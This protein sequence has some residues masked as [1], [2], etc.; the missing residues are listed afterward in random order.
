MKDRLFRASLL[1]LLSASL[2]AAGAPPEK[3]PPPRLLDLHGDP[4]PQGAVARL[5]S[6]RL[7][8]AGLADWAFLP[9]G[10][11]VA[12]V[13]GDGFVRFWDLATGRLVRTS[14]APASYA[15]ALSSDGR[16]V[17]GNSRS[18]VWVRDTSS[19]E[20]LN[21]ILYLRETPAEL[22]FAPDGRSLLAWGGGGLDL[23]DWPNGRSRELPGSRAY[24]SPEGGRVVA[25]AVEDGTVQGLTVI[26]RATRREVYRVRGVFDASA[27]SPDGKRLAVLG[28]LSGAKRGEDGEYGVRVVDFATGKELNRFQLKP[29]FGRGSLAFSPD[30][31]TL[32]VGGRFGGCLLDPD[33]GK[34]TRRVADCAERLRYSPDGK[35]LA[36]AAGPRL[37]LWDTATRRELHDQFGDFV[38]PNDFPYRPPPAASWDG[39]R[40]ASVDAVT[41]DLAVWDLADG[42]VVR[43]V[44]HKDL[45]RW[46]FMT[47]LQ[48][49]VKMDA[50]VSNVQDLAVADSGE[51]MVAYLFDKG[52]L[53][54]DVATGFERNR[55]PMPSGGRLA[56]GGRWV[57]QPSLEGRDAVTGKTLFKHGDQLPADPWLNTDPTILFAWSA[58]G[59]TAVLYH[60]QIKGVGLTLLAVESGRILARLSEPDVITARHL[61]GALSPDGRLLA[62]WR[63]TGDY[64]PLKLTVW[65]AATGKEVAVVPATLMGTEQMAFGVGGRLLVINDSAKGVRMWQL[66]TGRERPWFPNPDPVSKEWYS[67]AQGMLV[68]PDG[69]RLVA[70]HPDGTGIVWDL[71]ANA[72]PPA[73]WIREELDRWWSDLGGADAGAAWRAVWRLAEVPSDEVVPFLRR[74]LKTVAPDP[75]VVRRLVA[76]LDSDNFAAR[77]KASKELEQQGPEAIPMIRRALKESRSAESRQRLEAVLSR[78]A[79]QQSRRSRAVAVLEDVGSAAAREVLAELAGGAADTPETREAKAALE[80]LSRGR[81]TQPAPR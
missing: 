24:F 62:A 38:V 9:D 31:K 6:V 48:G 37:R 12:T 11:T 36:A 68:T 26:D 50:R 32:A 52:I 69:R 4:L 35:F 72:P 41:L 15:V 79:D 65:E 58:D 78:L 76:N 80:R 1:T 27:V 47:G 70:V 34:V 74:S 19:G 59:S 66:A 5:G 8:H 17:A 21:T 22:R 77:E 75:T 44:S 2:A 20:L 39:R 23:V 14:P 3:G 13:G 29:E 71:T 30:G 28:G 16:L 43:R 40:L 51:I 53:S 42:R 49:A 57:L 60:G 46:V 67:Q 25:D 56:G 55:V 45:V 33:T 64:G 81:P 7:R 18:G 54:W 63:Y 73:K 61:P 10:K